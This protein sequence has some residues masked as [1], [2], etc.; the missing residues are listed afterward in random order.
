MAKVVVLGVGNLLAGDDGVGVHAV[1]ALEETGLP[2]GV[3]AFD[4]GTA[5][6]DLPAEAEGAGKLI[7]IDAVRSGGKPGTVYR[8]DLDGLQEGPAGP[9]LSLHD[10]GVRQMLA[11]ARLSGLRLPPAVLV[12]VEV[13]DIS[14]R[15][16]L[17]APVRAAL[18]AVLRAVRQEFGLRRSQQ[19]AEEVRA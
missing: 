13:A 14:V 15:E 11:M 1:R 6:L 8:E 12:G 9:A 16:G 4:L 7:V 17:S 3:G 18:P 10:C 5:L 2:E 19:P